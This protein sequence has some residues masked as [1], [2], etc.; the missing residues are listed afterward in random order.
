MKGERRSAGIV[1]LRRHTDG[2][3]VLLLR[4]FRNWG[5]PKGRI[6]SGETPLAAALREVREETTLDDLV[7]AWGEA[8]CETEP[9]SG[10]KIARYY[11]AVSP[12]QPVS[13]PVN[14][15][16]GFAEHHEFQW[17]AFDAAR[18]RLVPRLQRVLDWARALVEA[19]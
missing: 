5:F 1:V 10:G 16:L 2:W 12:A 6:E 8:H 4:A 3:R 19:R 13:L 9:Y 14:P 17:L 15:A 7:F 11:V 18:A